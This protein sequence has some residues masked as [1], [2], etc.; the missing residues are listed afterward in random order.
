MT[1]DLWHLVPNIVRHFWKTLVR[2][3]C[4][5]AAGW[6]L[7]ASAP[8]QNPPPAADNQDAGQ[9]ADDGP[10]Q[11]GGGRRYQNM[12]PADFQ[13][14]MLANLRE[15]LGVTN[16][17]EWTVIAPR[18][19]AVMELRRNTMAGGFGFRGMA[20]GG[21]N[22]N[23]PN[24][25]GTANPDLDALQAALTNQAPDAEI[26]ARLERFR[27]IRKQNEARLEKAR[28][29]LRAVLTVRQEAVAVMMGLLP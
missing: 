15:Q 18:L 11:G 28:E 12:T 3:A 19:T 27:E 24:F 9:T 13:A 1:S 23:R 5:V 16:D 29:D 20:G 14:R 4:V 26:K 7:S 17:D 8:A 10:Q 2:S 6:A 22:G 21:R 25:Q